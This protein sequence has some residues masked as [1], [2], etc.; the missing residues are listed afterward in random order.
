MTRL[1]K[2]I[3]NFNRTF[4]LYSRMRTNFAR[5]NTEE[6]YQLA[7]TQSF[8]IVIEL[9]WKVIKDMLFEKGIEVFAPRDVIKEAFSINL[10]KNA[11]L[12]IDMLKTR[13][14]CSHEY[15]QEKVNLMLK[16]IASI[17]Y[18]ELAEFKEWV[19]NE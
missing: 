3:E 7:M 8:E 9:G 4:D 18:D 19:N 16:E 6:T 1:Q 11:Q 2:R 15:N 10:L 17:Y 12:W 14:A 13:N 5:N